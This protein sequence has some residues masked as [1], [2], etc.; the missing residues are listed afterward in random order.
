MK[1]MKV[2]DLQEELE[3]ALKHDI[4]YFKHG[5]VLPD[6]KKLVKVAKGLNLKVNVHFLN[7]VKCVGVSFYKGDST[8]WSSV[9][10][11]FPVN[12]KEINEFNGWEWYPGKE[13]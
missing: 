13:E 5:V 3:F 10:A 1:V 12:Y 9:G 8:I 7:G 11:Y 4:D 2:G 6:S